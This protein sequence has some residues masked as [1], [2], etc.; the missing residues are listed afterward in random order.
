MERL[1]LKQQQFRREEEG[2]SKQA[3]KNQRK[4]STKYPRLLTDDLETMIHMSS[5]AIHKNDQS[6]GLGFIRSSRFIGYEP[7]TRS[8]SNKKFKA[9]SDAPCNPS[10]SPPPPANV[11]AKRAV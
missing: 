11:N 8:E 10:D 6:Q 7:K 9:T 3:K 4:D 1:T 2:E 5:T